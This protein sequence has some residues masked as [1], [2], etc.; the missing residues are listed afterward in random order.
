VS[1]TVTD[2]FFTCDSVGYFSL[3][4]NE[5]NSHSIHGSSLRKTTD[6]GQNWYPT[7]PTSVDSYL[8]GRL[9]AIHFADNDTGFV[10]GYLEKGLA[11]NPLIF[12][13]TDQGE[14][15]NLSYNP[16]DGEPGLTSIYFPSPDTGYAVG[17][18]G[19][20]LKSA[21]GGQSWVELT[22][23]TEEDLYSVYFINNNAGVAVGGSGVILRTVNGG[24][25]WA[26]QPSGTTSKLTSVRFLDDLVGIAG[27]GP[28]IIRTTDGGSQWS[29]VDLPTPVGV[30]E[31]P[32][33][34]VPRSIFFQNH[35]NPFNPTS[36][37]RF[38]LPQGSYVS[39]ILYDIHGREVTRLSGGYMGP[40]Y[41][42]TTWDGR[43]S[44]GREVPSGIY[45]ARLVTPVYAKSIKMLLLK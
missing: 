42:K 14:N 12:R 27:G 15:W 18:S 36:T 38:D 7:Y 25:S 33:A 4:R 16:H 19:L 20:I 11:L 10:A 35:P 32:A 22:S 5:P 37:I 45:I 39:L 31:W 13:T 6:A 23:G 29:Q 1:Y 40:G 41:H 3:Y 34:P 44:D 17:Y 8:W 9:L 43:N 2:L 21:D 30:T 26:E 24:D 28:E